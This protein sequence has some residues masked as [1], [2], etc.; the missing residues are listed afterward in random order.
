VW[1]WACSAFG[2]EKPTIAKYRFADLDVTPNPGTTSIAK[3]IFN[4]RL[5]NQYFDKESG[6]SNCTYAPRQREVLVQAIELSS[7]EFNRAARRLKYQA[8]SGPVF[9]ISRGVRS[10]VLLSYRDYETLKGSRAKSLLQAVAQ[11]GQA[12]E[13]SFDPPRVGIRSRGVDLC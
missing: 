7:R 2:D 5:D 13:I 3:V 8:D 1:Q 9:I 4:K 12:D 11:V 10:H 6:L